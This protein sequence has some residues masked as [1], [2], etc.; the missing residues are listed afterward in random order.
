MNKHPATMTTAEYRRFLDKYELS[1][2]PTG[3]MF[4]LSPRQSQRLA[5][6]ERPVP[7]AIAILIRLVLRGKITLRDVAGKD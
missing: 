6:G 3:R 2:V 5:S 1:Q 7:H 4:G